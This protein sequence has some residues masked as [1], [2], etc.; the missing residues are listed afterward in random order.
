MPE[1]MTCECVKRSEAKRKAAY[2]LTRPKSGERG[3]D[4]DWRAV[5]KQYIAAHPT[6][7]HDGCS[8]PATEVDHIQTV[9]DRPDLRLRWSNLRGMCRHHHSQRTARDQSFGMSAEARE[10]AWPADLQRSA[11]PLTI[12]CGPPG[13]GKTT[14]VQQQAGP[15]DII[16]DLDVIKAEL[17]GAAM[18]SAD[19]RWTAPALQERNCML[20]SLAFSDAPHAW[21][22]VSAP[23]PIERTWWQA[24]LGGSVHVMDIDEATCVARIN[25]DHR[26]VGHRDRMVT[27][28]LDWF[29][30]SRGDRRVFAPISR[31]AHPLPT[32]F[33]RQLGISKD[34]TDTDPGDAG[35]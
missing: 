33:S 5:R 4:A 27:R 23:E 32:Q 30:R 34:G 2:D 31:T 28:C 24:R 7:S 20:R 18:Y 15:R 12:V 17:A 21:F 19:A 25:A 3:Y 29:E 26:R 14:W 6:C 22:I 1:G 13:S 10:R 35:D 9:K 16:I 11:V 8:A